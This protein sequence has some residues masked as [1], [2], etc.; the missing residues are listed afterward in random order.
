MLNL[1]QLLVDAGSRN[2]VPRDKLSPQWDKPLVPAPTQHPCGLAGSFE[3]SGQTGQ[4]FLSGGVDAHSNLHE[5]HPAPRAPFGKENKSRPEKQKHPLSH[6]SL[7]HESEY[8]CGVPPDFCGT[9]ALSQPCP[10]CPVLPP[11]ELEA[12][13]E[14]AAIMEYDGGLSRASAEAAAGMVHG[15]FPAFSPARSSG[16]EFSLGCN[17]PALST[18][19]VTAELLTK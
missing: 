1:D 18:N 8:P 5:I 19:S 13:I 3:G 12:R 16:R 4:G 10:A 17:P 9:S 2:L 11:G 7:I 6:L 15:S 14:R